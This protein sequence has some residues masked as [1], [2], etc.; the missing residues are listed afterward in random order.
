MKCSTSIPPPDRRREAAKRARL[1]QADEDSARHS[2]WVET[3][4]RRTL[5]KQPSTEA[6]VKRQRTACRVRERASLNAAIAHRHEL[7]RFAS[8]WG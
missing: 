3:T 7:G 6:A 8:D 1:R 5:E 4:T 2:A